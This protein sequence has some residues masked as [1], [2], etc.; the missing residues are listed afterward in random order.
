MPRAPSTLNE[1]NKGEEEDNDNDDSVKLPGVPHFPPDEEDDTVKLPGAPK[2][3]PD[4]DLSHIN[5][6]STIQV[7]PP[8]DGTQKKSDSP[9][10]NH[11][12]QNITHH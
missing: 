8:T 6:S 12:L 3:L 2:Y 10:K 4:D 7:F 9:I 1:S 5:K 11:L